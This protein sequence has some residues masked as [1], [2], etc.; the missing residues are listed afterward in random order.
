MEAGRPWLDGPLPLLSTVLFPFASFPDFH[1]SH[2]CLNAYSFACVCALASCQGPRD[3]I[4]PW[5]PRSL[6]VQFTSAFPRPARMMLIFP[7]ATSR[8]DLGYMPNTVTDEVIF[9]GFS[10]TR[11]QWKKLRCPSQGNCLRQSWCLH[12][13]GDSATVQR[14]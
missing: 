7:D 9:C 8:L 14:E 4:R 5:A 3:S 10:G 11:K 6:P 13:V 2:Q 1:C 12:T